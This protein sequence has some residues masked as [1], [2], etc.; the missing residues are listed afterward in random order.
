M[1]SAFSSG[2]ED[3]KVSQ[4]FE[5]LKMLAVVLLTGGTEPADG[6]ICQFIRL[7]GTE[8]AISNRNLNNF[9]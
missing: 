7:S 5:G 3:T 1:T 9:V 8:Y 2:T 4:N 6:K